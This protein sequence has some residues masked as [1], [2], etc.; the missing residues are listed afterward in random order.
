MCAAYGG[1]NDLNGEAVAS[2]FADMN[3][4]YRRV[5][6]R[7]GPN[8]DDLGP[9]IDSFISP[10]GAQFPGPVA[11]LTNRGTFSSAEMHGSC[12]QNFS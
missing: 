10:A 4:L 5:R 2:R 9:F 7:D 1:G 11:V 12:V 3:R 6:F 8:H